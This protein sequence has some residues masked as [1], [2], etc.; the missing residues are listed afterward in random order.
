MGIP[1]GK[2]SK[3]SVEAKRRPKEGKKNEKL[4]FE[5][6]LVFPQHLNK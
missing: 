3:G 1:V 6:S 4:T 2:K 5:E